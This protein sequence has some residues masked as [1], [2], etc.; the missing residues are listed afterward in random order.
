MSCHCQE[1]GRVCECGEEL[2][3]LCES[4][5]ICKVGNKEEVQNDRREVSL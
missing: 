1:C 2:C 5:V 3:P 4:G